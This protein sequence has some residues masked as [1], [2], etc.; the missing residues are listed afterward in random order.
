[1][2]D[3][4][5][6]LRDFWEDYTLVLETLEE[7]QI[8][9]VRPVL[10]R[11]DTLVERTAADAEGGGLVHPSWLLCVYQRM[12]HSENKAVMKEGVNHLLEL[13]LLQRP[14]FALAFSQFVVGPFTDVL[15]ESSL[16]HRSVGQA[17]GECPEIGLKLQRFMVMFF[18]SLPELDRGRVLLQLLWRLSSQHWCAVPLLFLCQALSRLP[19]C[20][21]LST[22][23]L[24]ALREVLCCTMVTHQVLLRG[25][26]QCFLL[27]S[28]LCLTDVDPH[29]TTTEQVVC[30]IILS[31]DAENVL[32]WWWWCVSVLASCGP[33]SCG[34]ASCGPASCG[35]RP[36]GRACG[37][38]SVGSV[39]WSSVLWASVLWASVLWAS[40]LWAGPVGQHSVG[41]RPVGQRPVGQ[42]P[43]GQRPVRQRPVVQRPV[44]TDSGLEDDHH[45]T[46]QQQM[47]YRL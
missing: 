17:V 19:P 3:R 2:P 41:Q 30:G 6:V 13:R 27:H 34:P 38:H 1:M 5:S 12:F 42:R 44:P 28:A 15:T 45:C 10:N 39:L 4:K 43:V 14:D 22:D 26:T 36:V 47:S 24:H 23:G 37:Q 11:I 21:L 46:V 20:P 29:R 33:A 32:M 16:Y 35:Q 18:S 7:N 8:H 40:V 31:T 9:V 25:A